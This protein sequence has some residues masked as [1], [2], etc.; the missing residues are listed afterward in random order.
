MDKPNASSCFHFTKKFT[1]LKSIL[2]DGLRFSCSFEKIPDFALMEM[3][4]WG[5]DLSERDYNINL[6][7]MIMPMICFC[8]IPLSR[9]KYHTKKYG[10]FGLGISKSFL[11][12]MYGDSFNPVFYLRGERINYSFGLIPNE[13]SFIFNDLKR[14]S[15][16][17]ELIDDLKVSYFSHDSD[18]YYFFLL[19]LALCKPYDETD[20]NGYYCFYDE[21]EWRMFCLPKRISSDLDK[22]RIEKNWVKRY[23]EIREITPDRKELKARNTE[24]WKN[25][26]SYLRIPPEAWNAISHIVVKDEQQ[27]LELYSFIKSATHLLGYEV[28]KNN[29][30]KAV[31]ITKIK[32]M[33]EINEDF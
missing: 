10:Q 33:K 14:K 9:C 1:T 19:Q 7:G 12:E 8:D 4:Y 30:N 32:T 31:L 11:C 5:I 2:T 20:I 16:I 15:E 28:S 17:A 29:K 24:L 26:F 3:F 6:S 23:F 21:R 18:L 25:E 13:I 22:Y 27:R